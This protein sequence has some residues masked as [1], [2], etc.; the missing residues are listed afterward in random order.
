MDFQEIVSCQLATPALASMIGISHQQI[1]ELLVETSQKYFVPLHFRNSILLLHSVFT[2]GLH[3]Y[4]C[5]AKGSVNGDAYDKFELS[6]FVEPMAGLNDRSTYPEEVEN[7]DGSLP[8]LICLTPK[9]F[10]HL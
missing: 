4:T 7:P 2:M 9:I 8:S 10:K 5:T 1:R 6:E 3:V